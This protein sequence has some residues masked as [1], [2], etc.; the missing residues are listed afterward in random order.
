MLPSLRWAGWEENGR[1]TIQVL[2]GSVE[3]ERFSLPVWDPVSNPDRGPR[4]RAWLSDYYR[5]SPQERRAK[6]QNRF[7]EYV[8]GR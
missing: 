1:L 3:Q 8:L 6:Y 4:L 2:L 7:E 5:L